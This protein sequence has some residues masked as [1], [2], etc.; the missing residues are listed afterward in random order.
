MD[1]CI[2]CQIVTGK[3]PTWKIYEDDRVIAILDHRPVREGHAMVIPKIHVDHFID[4]DDELSAH[5]CKVGNIVGRKIQD[6]LKPKRVGF[7]VAG[8]GVAH[9]HYH[10][11]PMWD[12]FDV[13]SAQYA[14]IQN[15]NLIFTMAHIPVADDQAQMELAQRLKI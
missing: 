7:A 8:F 10:V 2:F 14:A 11:V 13:T 9:A 3:A 4:L 6:V 5:I 12:E 15:G 1:N